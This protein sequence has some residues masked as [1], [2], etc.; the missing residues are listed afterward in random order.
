MRQALDLHAILFPRELAA[1]TRRVLYAADFVYNGLMMERLALR[2]HR[3][4]S[5]TRP[6]DTA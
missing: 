6:P 3:E 1:K 5:N 4:V 2:F